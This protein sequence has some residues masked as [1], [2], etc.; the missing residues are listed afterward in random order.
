MGRSDMLGRFG[1]PL[2]HVFVPPVHTKVAELSVVDTECPSP[3]LNHVIKLPIA[4]AL[5]GVNIIAIDGLSISNSLQ[6]VG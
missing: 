2:L 3:I 1:D 6:P 4:T 5:S